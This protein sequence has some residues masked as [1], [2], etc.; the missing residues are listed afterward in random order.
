M[1]YVEGKTWVVT[2]IKNTFSV[3]ENVLEALGRA[4]AT[5]WIA[6]QFLWVQR[7]LSLQNNSCLAIWWAYSDLFVLYFPHLLSCGSERRGW[8]A[9]KGSQ[10]QT[11]GACT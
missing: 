9:F 11:Y 6:A 3:V 2:Y 5:V 8:S 4:W 7:L 1:V 10:M